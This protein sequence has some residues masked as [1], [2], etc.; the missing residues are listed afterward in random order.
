MGLLNKT[1]T[2]LIGPMENLDGT[3]WR[4][5]VEERLNGIGIICYNPYSKPFIANLE[6]GEEVRGKIKKAINSG[7]L[8]YSH[9]VG[10]PIRSHD[11]N[12][13]DRSDFIV[14]HIHPTLASYGTAEELATANRAKK[15]IFLSIDGGRNNCPAWITWMIPPKYIYNN[16]EEILD[17]LF[18]IDNGSIIADSDRWR[19]LKQ[20]YR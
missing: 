6:E 19:L 11:L 20:C 16:I 1:K 18:K 14:G 2:Y 7:D 5:K 13:V 10:K 3:G 9:R 12:L 8:E 17:I 4:K 15:P